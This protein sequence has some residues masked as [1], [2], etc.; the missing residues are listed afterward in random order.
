M[1]HL[2]GFDL[3]FISFIDYL[4]FWELYPDGGW[5]EKSVQHLFAIIKEWHNHLPNPLPPL[6][7][8]LLNKF[9]VAIVANEVKLEEPF[10]VVY[11]CEG[12]RFAPHTLK[13]LVNNEILQTIAEHKQRE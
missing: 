8:T 6:Y 2:V 1:P 13:I 10:L 4:L 5:N 7:W 9:N 12:K 3:H 11:D